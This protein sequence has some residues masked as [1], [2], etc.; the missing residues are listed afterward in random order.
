MKKSTSLTALFL[1][2]LVLSVANDAF[3]GCK[4]PTSWSQKDSCLFYKFEGSNPLDSAGKPYTDGCLKYT[5]DFGDSSVAKG[6]IVNH[7]Y[8]TTG[9]YKVCLRIQDTC[10]GCDTTIC[11]TISVSCSS[12]SSG[13]KFP[14]GWTQR[15]S[16]AFFAFEGKNPLDS[17]GKPY[18]DTCL[19]Y[20]WSFGDSTVATGRIVTHTYSKNGTYSVCLRIKNACRGCDTLICKTVSVSCLS[21]GS[22]TCYLPDGW[23]STSDSCSNRTFEGWHPVDSTGKPY[24]DTCLSYLW[25]FGDSSVAKGRVVKHHFAKVGS[26]KVCLTVVNNCN[27]CDTTICGIIAIP[28]FSP[29]ATNI[30]SVSAVFVPLQIFPNPAQNAFS[31]RAAGPQQYRIIDAFGREL[32]SGQFNDLITLSTASLSSGVYTVQCIGTEGRQT[33]RLLISR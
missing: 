10:R 2:F 23:S 22:R 3:A 4:L 12:S 28:C 31:L 11:K 19:K 32:M 13:C 29:A 18:T 24:V 25:S 9:T 20:I 5:W 7:T 30:Q 17:A 26:Y 33:V 6:R 21:G 1:L 14:E 27:G 15:D 8:P 16:C